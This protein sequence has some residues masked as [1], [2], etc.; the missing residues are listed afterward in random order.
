MGIQHAS[1]HLNEYHFIEHVCTL[2]TKQDSAVPVLDPTFT[3]WECLDL[4]VVTSLLLFLTYVIRVE[5]SL[6][7]TP[8]H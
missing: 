2:V 7:Q 1:C 6:L 5:S 3:F 8:S 4:F